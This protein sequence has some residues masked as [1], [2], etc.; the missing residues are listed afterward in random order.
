MTRKLVVFD[1]DG[2]L[3]NDDHELLP[4]TLEAIQKIQQDGHMVMCATGRSLPIAKDVLDEAGITDSILSNGAVAF[5]NGERVYSNALDSEALKK[6]I[7]ISDA[8]KIDLVFNG[9]TETK[10]RNEKFQPHTKL[11]MESFGENMPEIERDFHK[12]EE[13]FQVVALLDEAKMRAY[14]GEFPEFRFVRWHEF[15]IDILPHDGSKAE[16]LKYVSE[17]YGF[18]REDIIA[19]GDGNNDMEML[20]FAGTG[21]A[22]ANAKDDLKAVSDFVTLT[23]NEGGICHGLREVGLI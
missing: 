21:I 7:E 16:T 8:E 5:V 17:K 15:G 4:E 3:I 2:T 19:F 9:L 6:L 13:V 18:K 14:E 20:Q 1:I 12:R 22:M 10:L 23:N 11:A